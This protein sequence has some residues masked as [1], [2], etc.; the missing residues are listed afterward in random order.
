MVRSSLYVMVRALKDVDVVEL[1]F[2]TFAASGALVEALHIMSPVHSARKLYKPT[3]GGVHVQE[4][5]P[6]LGVPLV[7]L[8]QTPPSSAY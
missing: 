2:S 6:S 4:N 1:A 7:M 8:V 3:A 5:F